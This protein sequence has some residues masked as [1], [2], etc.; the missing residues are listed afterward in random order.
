MV[1]AESKE[2]EKEIV[3][4]FSCIGVPVEAFVPEE[5]EP[6]IVSYSFC[7]DIAR[8]WEGLYGSEIL[9]AE[10]VEWLD[11]ALR[12]DMKRLRYVRYPNENELMLEYI[13]SPGMHM[14]KLEIQ[15]KVH[16]I[17]S[18][19]VLARL[20]ES[21]GCDIEIADDGEDAVFAIVENGIILA[22]A[23]M[24]D[25]TYEDGSVEISVETAPD[26]RRKGY[27][28]AVVYELTRHLL[29]KGICVRYKCSAE[30]TASSALAE[31]CGYRLEG[32]RLSMVYERI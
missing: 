5:G 11:N 32:K 29:D 17:Y 7:M 18:N 13:A 22:Y 1:K 30:N 12:D 3:N 2:L 20:C 15:H 28:A 24:N 21:S 14:P 4:G 6:L 9:S 31:K 25:L 27:G 16:K 23:G 19:A 26:C 8:E 10:S